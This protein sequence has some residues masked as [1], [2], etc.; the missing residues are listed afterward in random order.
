MLAVLTCSIE[1]FDAADPRAQYGNFEVLSDGKN[2]MPGS[3]EHSNPLHYKTLTADTRPDWFIGAI[4]PFSSTTHE[5]PDVT[6]T[7]VQLCSAEPSAAP[8][9]TKEAATP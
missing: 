7:D 2:F 8:A 9:A 1:G 3:S 4:F 6:I 5:F